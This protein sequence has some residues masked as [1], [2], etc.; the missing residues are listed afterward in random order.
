MTSFSQQYLP[1]CLLH[2]PTLVHLPRI[3]VASQYLLLSFPLRL[4]IA[5]LT[6]FTCSN[7]SLFIYFSPFSSPRHSFTP[8]AF[9]VLLPIDYIHHHHSP[10]LPH[11][12]RT[13]SSNSLT[14]ST[15]TT[16]FPPSFL[17]R[18][19]ILSTSDPH[20]TPPTCRK[21]PASSCMYITN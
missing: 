17:R 15:F 11:S 21:G 4:L 9:T 13:G 6:Y 14:F 18:P 12:Y 5:F 20:R 8:I 19:Y 10:S 7:N 16:S 1:L 2:F 3:T